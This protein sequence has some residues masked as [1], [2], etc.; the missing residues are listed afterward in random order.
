MYNF[1]VDINVSVYRDELRRE[2]HSHILSLQILLENINN[3]SI[4]NREVKLG[5]LI[6]MP[7]LIHERQVIIKN[8]INKTFISTIRSFQNFIDKLIAT[9]DLFNREYKNDYEIK[10]KKEFNS[11][12]QKQLDEMINKVST[13]R[14][15]GFSDK[16]KK[17]NIDENT[18]EILMGY[19]TL[20]NNLEHHKDISS[21]DTELNFFVTSVYVNNNELQEL[22][23]LLE[24]G[25]SINVRKKS[26]TRLIN[27][28]EKVEILEK[29]IFE[30]IFTLSELISVEFINA[31]YENLK[32]IKQYYKS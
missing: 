18:K 16:L 25:S 24:Q 31:T 17:F 7:L 6:K 8:E 9:T 22:N 5:N 1:K 30:I 14:Y 4:L 26:I 12:L 28:G 27:K 32:D 21:K 11:F 23:Q 19:T 13:N 20:R 15:F 3:D 2:L 29:E 10:S